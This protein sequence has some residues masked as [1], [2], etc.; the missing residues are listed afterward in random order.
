MHLRD[1]L[2]SR[3]FVYGPQMAPQGCDSESPEK[4]TFDRTK[5]I[6]QIVEDSMCRDCGFR[7]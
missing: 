7:R 4:M 2:T 5:R 3:R 1:P 6:L